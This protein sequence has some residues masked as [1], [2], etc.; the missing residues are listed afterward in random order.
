MLLSMVQEICLGS[1][2]WRLSNLIFTSYCPKLT[3]IQINYMILLTLK[4]PVCLDCCLR[5]HRG[6][7]LSV[8]PAASKRQPMLSKSVYN[9]GNS[10]TQWQKHPLRI[11]MYL[12]LTATRRMIWTSLYGKNKTNGKQSHNTC[13]NFHVH[14]ESWLLSYKSGIT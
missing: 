5:N 9:Y 3:I 4:V 10:G 12:R 7:F 11:H 2:M 13:N 8:S 1:K 14:I 6:T